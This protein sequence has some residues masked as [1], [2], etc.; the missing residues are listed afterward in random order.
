M[1]SSLKQ[2]LMK[3]RHMLHV[4]CI[5]AAET[6]TIMLLFLPQLS[7]EGSYLTWLSAFLQST[8][9]IRFVVCQRHLFHVLDGVLDSY[10]HP[11]YDERLSTESEANLCW[12]STSLV[13]LAPFVWGMV[14][15]TLC[16]LFLWVNPTLFEL[17]HWVILIKWWSISE[18]AS[19]K[20]K[21]PV[22]KGTLTLHSSLNHAL[23]RRRHTLHVY[24]S[25][26]DRH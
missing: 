26:R 24:L 11:C 18:T 6:G 15:V 25:S 5:S 22:T 1:H 23:M 2:A 19:P 9:Q 14:N 4:Y 3:R 7:L 8:Y 13:L 20:L 17:F 12:P 10:A 21:V 16:Q